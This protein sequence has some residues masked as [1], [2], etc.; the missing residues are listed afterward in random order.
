MGVA[1]AISIL[2]GLVL[3]TVFYLIPLIVLAATSL[4]D[5]SGSAYE[6]I[7]FEN[8]STLFA[9]DRFLKAARN[10]AL[11][12]MVAV[13]IQVPLGVIVGVLLAQRLP[14][15]TFFRAIL[16]IPYVISGAAFALIFA[17]F[18][19]PRYGLL[20]EIVGALGLGDGHDWLFSASTALPAIAGTFIFVIGFHVIVVMAEIA[21]I[22][23]ELY[24]AAALDGAGPIQRHRY[25]TLPLIR[26]VV[27]TLVLLALLSYLAFFDVVYILTA[28]GPNDATITLTL[29]AYRAYANGAW[30]FANAVGLMIVVIGLIAIVGVRRVFRIGERT[31]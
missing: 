22:P 9:D 27:G 17:F 23:R 28:G 21:S 4:A 13:F 2:P 8:Y 20:N 26:N 25:L 16:F 5:W 14:G 31:L 24:E 1:I 15:W 7:G 19:N 10:T 3:C 12:C 29:Y 30:G 18:Y 11:F 6:Y